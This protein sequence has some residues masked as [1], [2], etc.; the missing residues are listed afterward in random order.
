[1]A[2]VVF[3]HAHPDDECLTTGGTIARLA[4]EGHRIVLVTA[5]DGAL[6]ECPDGLLEA[7]ES[8]ADR[9]AAELVASAEVLGVA[10]LCMLGHADSGMVGTDGN[11]NPQAFCN[12]DVEAAAADLARLL[13]DEAADVLVAYDENGGY[14]HPDHIQVHRVGLRAA[15]M[16][17]TPAVY[18]STIN[19]DQLLRFIDEA[20]ESGLDPFEGQDAPNRGEVASFGVP[21]AEITTFVDVGAFVPVK[22]AAMRCHETQVGD[23]GFFLKMSEAAFGKAFGREFFVRL[24]APEGTPEDHLF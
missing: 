5:T 4:A 10:S 13:H 15:E 18:Q 22:L 24:R 7:G 6:G 8:L 2:T 9:R 17:G 21:E 20:A 1:V 3:L 19:R 16:A 14:G 11:D 23:M 12:V